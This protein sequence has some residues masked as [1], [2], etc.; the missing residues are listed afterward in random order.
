MFGVLPTVMVITLLSSKAS[1]VR[2]VLRLTLAI[3]G[4]RLLEMALSTS[5]G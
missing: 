4:Q 1:P 3:P 5:E 2:A